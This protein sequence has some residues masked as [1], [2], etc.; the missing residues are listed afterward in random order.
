MSEP[1]NAIGWGG[2]GC[3]EW[4]VG[5]KEAAVLGDA[6]E[7]KHVSGANA[8]SE[9]RESSTAGAFEKDIPLTFEEGTPLTRSSKPVTR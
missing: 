9:P 8:R 3:T 7:C 6:R 2:S 5:L 4:W 1:S